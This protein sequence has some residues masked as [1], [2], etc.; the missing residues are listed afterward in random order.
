M[1]RLCW[2]CAE[3]SWS[4]SACCI[5]PG[6]PP[7]GKAQGRAPAYAWLP[8]SD[9]ACNAAWHPPTPPLIPANSTPLHPQVAHPQPAAPMRPT[10]PSHTHTDTHTQTHIHTHTLP[11][12]T[13]GPAPYPLTYSGCGPPNGP[14]AHALP[15]LLH[16]PV[17][18]SYMRSVSSG[19][20]ASQSAS[21]MSARAR[22]AHA[23]S[24]TAKLQRPSQSDPAALLSF[25]S[26]P[27]CS[28]QRR[29]EGWFGG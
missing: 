13:P 7:L 16:P 5:A 11:S 2:G 26:R 3:E 15:S 27:L 24:N 28:H 10:A 18:T 20:D 4:C 8:D 12:P 17:A 22:C 21:S 25:F 9:L 6:G 29:G 19:A 1:I 14:C 23:V